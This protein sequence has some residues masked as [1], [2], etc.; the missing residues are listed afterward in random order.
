MH[1]VFQIFFRYE[2]IL[3]IISNLFVKI[4]I[5]QKMHNHESLH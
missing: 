1:I 5:H 4:L 2:F 3:N